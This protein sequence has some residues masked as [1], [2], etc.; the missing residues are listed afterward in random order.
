MGVEMK[1]ALLGAMAAIALLSGCASMNKAIVGEPTEPAPTNYRELVLE[2]AKTTFYD[3]YSVRDA[4][5]SAPQWLGSVHLGEGNGWQVCVRANA[6]N[7]M[8]A[9]VGLKE[10]AFFF[11]GGKVISNATDLPQGGG[12]LC[13]DALYAP[14]TELMNLQ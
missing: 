2:T 8:G 12:Y 13:Q 7:Q 11:R 3:P 1:A 10:T 4:E 5:I 6:K 14:F 9:Y